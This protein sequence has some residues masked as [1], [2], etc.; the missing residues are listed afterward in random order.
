MK[1]RLSVVTI[2]HSHLKWLYMSYN[3]TPILREKKVRVKVCLTGYDN[4]L[5]QKYKYF[6]NFHAKIYIFYTSNRFL[7]QILPK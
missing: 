5:L 4:F 6:S 7:L 3:C 1:N 2:N